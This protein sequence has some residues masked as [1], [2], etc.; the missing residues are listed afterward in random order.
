M[1][2]CNRD[3][4]N[5]PY[6]DC[7]QTTDTEAEIYSIELRNYK[8]ATND[9]LNN[10]RIDYLTRRER[11]ISQG[12]E[13]YRKHREERK[14]YQL[15]YHK[16]KVERMGESKFCSRCYFLLPNSYQFSLCEECREKKRN[17]QK[18]RY[19]EKKAQ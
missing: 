18:I 2:K 6:D 4:F 13:Y 9:A 3:C 19:K 12:K 14:R 8:D 16:N 5:C 10:N 7:M 17:Y 1:F 11:K 15:N